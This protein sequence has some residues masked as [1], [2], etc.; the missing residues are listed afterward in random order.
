MGKDWTK[1]AHIGLSASTGQLSDNHDIIRLETYVSSDAA[2]KGEKQ[3]E[4]RVQSDLDPVRC[5]SISYVGISWGI[6]V[7]ASY[8][9]CT[10]S[11]SGALEWGPRR[12][13]SSSRAFG[14]DRAAAE[15]HAVAIA[16]GRGSG[17]SSSKSKSGILS[18]STGGC[19]GELLVLTV[20]YPSKPPYHTI[21]Y[22]MYY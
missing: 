18:P 14:S 19:V 1:A 13:Y 9:S 3:R 2:E 6:R 4:N 15:E 22:P 17:T 21:Q 12:Y 20:S 7:L 11:H 8:R 5:M 10:A 16:L